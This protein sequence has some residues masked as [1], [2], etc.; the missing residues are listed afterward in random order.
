MVEWEQSPGPLTPGKCSLPPHVSLE[1]GGLPGPRA[2]LQI[3]TW[4]GSDLLEG[5]FFPQGLS[6]DAWRHNFKASGPCILTRLYGEGHGNLLQVFLIGEFHGQKSLTVYSPWGCKRIGLD[7]VTNPVWWALSIYWELMASE[8]TKSALASYFFIYQ[9]IH[10]SNHSSLQTSVNLSKLP[11]THP[12][13]HPSI[14]PSIYPSINSSIHLSIHWS[15]HPSVDPSI[16][17][18][19]HPSIHPSLYPSICPLIHPPTQP[20]THP[21]IHP[22]NLWMSAPMYQA[23]C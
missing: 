17:S 5:D 12:T 4:K 8:G 20:S 22:T 16:H 2:L 3:S 7:L 14:H 6:E 11:S 10:P 13:F 19:I 18:L 21:S 1:N 15:I 23:P 9:S